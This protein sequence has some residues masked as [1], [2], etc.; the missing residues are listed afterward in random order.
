MGAIV[1]MIKEIPVIDAD[2]T[3]TLQKNLDPN[4][5]FVIE[6]RNDMIF[7]EYY[8]NIIKNEKIVSGDLQKIFRGVNAELLSNAI[9]LETEELQKDHYMYLGR[10]LSKAEYA[11][12]S[13]TTYEQDC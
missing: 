6:L 12:H 4:G 13:H 10:E 8:K 3:Y 9:L 7:V 5:F 2:E 11:L 1:H